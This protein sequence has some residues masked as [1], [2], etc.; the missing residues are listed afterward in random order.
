[1]TMTLSRRE[2]LRGAACGFGGLALDGLMA[3]TNAASNRRAPGGPHIPPRA[4]RVIFVFLAGGP[5]QGDLFAPKAYITRKHGQAI[6]SPVGDDGQLRVG[7]AQFLPMAP[8]KP[9]RPR[10]QSG[11]MMSDLLPHLSGVA[12]EL[13]LLRAVVADNKAHAPAALQF[14]TGHIA[15]ARPSMGAWLGY[16]L[17]TE[18]RDMPGFITI[19]PPGDG[20]TYGAGFLPAIHQGTPLRVPRQ[21][22]EVA[23]TNLRDPD[24]KPELQRQRL[25][26]LQRINRRLLNRVKTDSQ[27]E[28]I[29]ESFELAF[30]MQA[31]TPGLVDLSRE[32]KQTLEMYG[33]GGGA[34]DVNGR[35]CLMARRLS[36]AGVRFVQ[37]T[38]GGWDHHGDIRNAL[39][40]SCARADQPIAA[41]IRDLKRRGLLDDTLLVVSGEFGRTY[42]SQDLSG[43]SPIEKHGREHQQESFCTLLAGGGVKAGLVHGETDDF[44]YRPV[45]G[46]VHLHDLHATILHLL[47]IDHERLTFKYQ[48]RYFRLTD[49]HG[50]VVK[51]ALA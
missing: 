46:Q 27:M 39:P 50:H 31:K 10:G 42:W 11:M 36:E 43:T 25:D 9:V 12:D 7:V 4:K 33:I 48:G 38:I 1:M 18:N 6:K 44:G 41:L 28:G 5:S 15:E 8:V 2:L 30:R 35:A 21:T 40:G 47:G 32:S 17:G 34:S 37:V 45:Q 24:P 26:F 51:G 49:V 3:D 16:G 13:C 23:I 14:H 29:I 20:R 22:G 19:H